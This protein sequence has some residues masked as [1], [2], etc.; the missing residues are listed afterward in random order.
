MAHSAA[1]RIR[2]LMAR[3]GAESVCQMDLPAK[4]EV[5]RPSVFRRA[6][7]GAGAGARGVSAAASLDTSAADGSFRGIATLGR[8]ML[9][10]F[11]STGRFIGISP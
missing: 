6:G 8:G 4:L 11:G 9:G 1:A 7:A 10:N 3:K 5:G 2:Q